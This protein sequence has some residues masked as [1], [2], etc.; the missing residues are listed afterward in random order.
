MSGSSNVIEIGRWKI[1]S[2][3]ESPRKAYAATL[4]GGPEECGCRPCLNFAAQ[5]DETYPPDVMQLF[6]Q[7]G[8]APNRETEI[9]HMARLESGKHLYGGW[10]HFVGSIISS[11]DAAQKIGENIWQPN[12]EA[13]S[14]FFF[15]GIRGSC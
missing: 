5:R 12:L 14:E 10:F 7:L 11:A 13:R 4:M 9:Y 6:E 3:A 15:S 8:I 2:D 1:A